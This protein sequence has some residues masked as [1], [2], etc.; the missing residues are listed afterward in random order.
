MKIALSDLWWYGP[1]NV[2]N[3]NEVLVKT[4]IERS[5]EVQEE[6]VIQVVMMSNVIQSDTPS[7]WR[8][9][10]KRHSSWKRVIRICGWV[11]R[12]ITS[13]RRSVDG[14]IVGKLLP[15]EV[16]DAEDWFIRS[17]QDERFAEEYRLLKKGKG[18]LLICLQ[19]T[20]DDHGIMRCSSRM[21]NAEFLQIT[22][23]DPVI[24]PR[25]SWV[26]KLIIKQYHEDGHHSTGINHALAV[27]SATYWIISTRQV[28]REVEKDC[29]VCRRRKAKLATQVMAPLLPDVRLKMSLRPFANA[30]VD[31]TEPFIIIQGRSIRRAKQNLCLFTCLNAFLRMVS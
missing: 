19:P 12:F 9:N 24:L 2:R 3:G 22:T 23:R 25:S 8:L 10:P 29:V 20:M 18:I 30:V 28:I 16:K 4:D 7:L 5:S 14:K 1:E 13:V 27:L 6:K 31:Y 21:V 11:I 17:A 26:T 15:S